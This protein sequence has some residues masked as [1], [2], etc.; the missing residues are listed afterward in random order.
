MDRHRRSPDPQTSAP[1]RGQ[2]AGTRARMIAA[3]NR[4]LVGHRAEAAHS[5]AADG[6]KPAPG[7]Q[8]E[9]ALR[10]MS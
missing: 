9:W 8:V 10:M 7:Q 1:H 2:A 5:S 3:I 4:I 6:A